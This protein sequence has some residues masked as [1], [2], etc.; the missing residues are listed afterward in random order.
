MSTNYK[1]R[2]DKGPFTHKPSKKDIEINIEQRRL[3]NRL[4]SESGSL[5]S[6]AILMF[7]GYWSK[8][9]ACMDWDL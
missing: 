5:N 6:I 3:D 8:H 1:K 2:V 9:G 7:Y 4:V